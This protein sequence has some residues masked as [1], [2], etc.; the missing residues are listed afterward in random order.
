MKRTA[1]RLGTDEAARVIAM[2]SPRT[3]ALFSLIFDI[4]LRRGLST[5]RLAKAVP[6]P[7]PTTPRLVIYTNHPSWWD[8]VTYSFLSRRLFAGRPMFSPID[9]AMI[10]RYPFMARCG[11][12]GVRLHS[13]RG[14][15]AFLATSR[16]IL[17]DR[18]NLLI[19]ACQGRFSDV[20][21]RPLRIGGGLAH[22]AAREIGATFVPLAIE[23]AFWDERRPELLLRFGEALDCDALADLSLEERRLALER[24]LDEAMSALAETSIARD[25]GAFETLVS[26]AKGINPIYDAWRRMKAMAKGQ[27]F[28]PRHGRGP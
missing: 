26:G 21:E 6:V 24:R 9:A 5:V 8:A 3:V 25:A 28:D 13:V 22:L 27:S 18:N 19:V 15:L 7:S 20:R 10:E 11:V 2:R 16:A 17:A 12:F 14:A 1:L 4:S 23:Y